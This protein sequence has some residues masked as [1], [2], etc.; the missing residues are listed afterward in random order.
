MAKLETT[1]SATGG[2]TA[3]QSKTKIVSTV[4]EQGQPCL[5][6][7]EKGLETGSSD[8]SATAN[9]HLHDGVQYVNGYPIIRNGK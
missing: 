6:S 5:S 4:R 3:D 9:E 2:T 1:T 8:G 7:G